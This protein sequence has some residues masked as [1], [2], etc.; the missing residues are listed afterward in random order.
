MSIFDRFVSKDA[1]SQKNKTPRPN[2][3]R[4]GASELEDAGADAR[5]QYPADSA[6]IEDF[7]WNLKAVFRDRRKR[8]ADGE[9]MDAEPR[10]FLS[11]DRL[12]VYACVLPPENGGGPLALEDFLEDMHYEGILFGILTEEIPGHFAKG[13]YHIF[14]VARG[15]APTAGE[16]GKVTELFQR[17]RHMRLEVQN[18]SEVDF[19]QDVPLQPVQRGTPICLIRQPR[20]GTDGMDVTGAV[21][22]APEVPEVVVPQ[23]QNVEL[24]RGGQALVAGTDGILYIE[25]DRFCIHA[26]K[27]INGD[28]NQFQGTLEVSGNLYVGGD[29]DGG[30]RIVVSGDVVIAGKVGQAQVESTVGIIRVQK[31]IYG[32]PEKTVLKAESQVQSPVV[33]CAQISAG[34]SVITETIVD[35]QIVCNGTVYAMTGRGMIANSNIRAGGSILCLRVGNL[36]GGRSYFSVGYPPHVPEE[37]QRIKGELAQVQSVVER[38]WEAISA[39][40]KKGGRISD[41]EKVI[42][43]RLV[44]QR[45]L[46]LEKLENLKADLYGVNKV[47]EK[48]SKG[49]I[50]CEE[51]YPFLDVRIGNLAEEI[52]T[53]EENCSIHAEGNSILMNET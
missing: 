29:V 14:P 52:I 53:I 23:G 9:T 25:S 7:V 3:Y 31:G 24:G 36:A 20:A 40:R 49:R 2:S 45:G 39:L 1:D 12:T 8:A 35:S 41:D 6:I 21:L 48:R 15:R 13:Y 27:I 50:R 42:L 38:L 17:R 11:Q 47:L 5:A 26:Q 46:Y 32:T 16:E 10:F 4:K 28:L 43:G 19:S 51:L 34:A 30:V 22:P 37:K 18:G 33:E 44:E